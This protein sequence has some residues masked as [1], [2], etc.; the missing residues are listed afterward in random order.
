MIKSMTGYGR[1]EAETEN[2]KIKVVIEIK[3]V[4]SRYCDINIKG[5]KRYAFLDEHI[6]K[7][8]KERVSSVDRKSVV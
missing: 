3:S 6:R 7:R 8:V 4:N 5:T 1:G 2:K